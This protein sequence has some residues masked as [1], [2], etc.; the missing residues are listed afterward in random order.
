MLSV[1]FKKYILFPLST[2]MG[3]ILSALVILSS[4]V[5]AVILLGSGTLF[6]LFTGNRKRII[7]P[8]SHK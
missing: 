2:F 7:D 1:N 8:V 3:A 4:T 6:F 5:A